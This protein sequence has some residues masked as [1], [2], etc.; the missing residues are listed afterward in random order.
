MHSKKLHSNPDLTS[1]LS[2]QIDCT[3]EVHLCRDHT[4]Q[5]FPSIR[6]FRKGSDEVSVHGTR[7]HESYRGDRTTAALLAFTENLVPSAGQP[8][9]FIRCPPPLLF[10][11]PALPPPKLGILL[12]IKQA[13]DLPPLTSVKCDGLLYAVSRYVQC[14]T[15]LGSITWK[16]LK[17]FWRTGH[18][19][20]TLINDSTQSFET[21]KGHVFCNSSIAIELSRSAGV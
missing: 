16:M 20:F 6:V 4:I 8:H 10:P 7:D 18:C 5:G 2:L 11:S 21:A 1:S 3:I 19:P 9:H 13:L 17:D 15:F 12:Q 14:A